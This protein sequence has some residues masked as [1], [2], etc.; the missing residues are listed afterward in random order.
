[1]QS[2]KSQFTDDELT[3]MM[4]EVPENFLGLQD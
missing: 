4:S 1:M 2:F 3:T